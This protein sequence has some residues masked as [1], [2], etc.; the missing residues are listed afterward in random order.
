[1]WKIFKK[2]VNL[3]LVLILQVKKKRLLLML[4]I[5][6]GKY[7]IAMIMNMGCALF[8]TSIFT[9]KICIILMLF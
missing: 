2:K 8:Y 6:Q 3:E 7:I 4:L 1:M 9:V 5:M